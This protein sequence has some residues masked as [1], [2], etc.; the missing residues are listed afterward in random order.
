MKASIKLAVVGAL[1]LMGG[2]ANAANINTTTSTANGSQLL[3]L[4]NNATDKA[5]LAF[6]LTPTVQ[7]VKA[8]SILASDPVSQYSNDGPLAVNVHGSLTVP[9]ALNGYSTPNLTSYLAANVGENITWTILGAKTSGSTAAASNVFVYTSVIPNQLD[10]NWIGGDVVTSAGG[11]AS[12]IGEINGS[13]VNNGVSTTGGY[14]SALPVGSQAPAS[15]FSSAN[16]ANGAALGSAQSLFL[17]A[18][19]ADSA[20]AANV[21]KSAY[22]L[23]LSS[24][25]LLSY[26]APVSAVPVP[27]A[28]WLLGSG[29]MGL[30]GIGRRRNATVAA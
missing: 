13:V 12:L 29:L 21:Y 15:F 16:A 17:V 26:D 27:A 4:L 22:T 9:A 5:F 24:A 14:G 7:D 23:T 25:G 30:V 11:V 3:L 18:S 2:V 28:I 1:A 20:V 8:N 19:T 10:S 6:E